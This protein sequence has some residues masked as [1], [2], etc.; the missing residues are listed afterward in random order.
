M[1][2]SAGMAMTH[3]R[4]LLASSAMPIRD[5]RTS[6]ANVLAGG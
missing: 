6:S 1:A 5:S 3:Y 2:P 4:A